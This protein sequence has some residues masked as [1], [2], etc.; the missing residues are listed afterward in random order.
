MTYKEK[1]KDDR[2]INKRNE[3]LSIYMNNGV[4]CMGCGSEINLNVHHIRYLPNIEP[5][6]YNNTYLVPLCSSCHHVYHE[7]KEKLTT[8]LMN[9]RLYFNYE[10][11]LIISIVNKLC[12]LETTDI[13]KVSKIINYININSF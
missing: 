2:W 11:E 3:V 12:N 13:K 9:N 6:E 8:L 10:F 5:W 7:N 4:G 1:L